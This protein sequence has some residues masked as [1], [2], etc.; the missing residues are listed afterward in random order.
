MFKIRQ[1]KSAS[2]NQLN[3]ELYNYSNGKIKKTHAYKESS[4]RMQVSKLLKHK[5]PA[6]K[7]TFYIYLWQHNYKNLKS[8]LKGTPDVLDYHIKQIDGLIAAGKVEPF[9]IVEKGTPKS[10]E[11]GKKVLEI[12][13]YGNLRA[14][15]TFFNIYRELVRKH[16]TYCN[17]D[18][19]VNIKLLDGSSKALFDLDHY[20]PKVKYPYLSISFF[21]LIP[22]CSNCNS[23]I[24]G[25]QDLT[26]GLHAHPFCDNI[27]ENI[28]FTT[29]QPYINGFP[30][31]I[32]AEQIGTDTATFHKSLELFNFL[33]IIP[34]YK[35]FDQEVARL[36]KVSQRYSITEKNELL[37]KLRQIDPLVAEQDTINDILEL[38]DIPRSEE[39]AANK[40]MG[41]FKLDFAERFDINKWA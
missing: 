21:N 24:K 2:L 32:T 22:A 29:V 1:G 41:K 18:T 25:S 33:Q 5:L 10:T 7:R 39:E 27:H 12:F 17:L 37:K 9:Y 19:T 4:I 36:Y 35:E 16:C 38:T 11:F 34:R 28:S 14:T 23:R 8:I 3:E 15:S 20:F 6:T 26:Y 31:E 13:R 30:F 40:F